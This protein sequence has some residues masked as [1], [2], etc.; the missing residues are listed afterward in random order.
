MCYD[1][2]QQVSVLRKAVL[3]ELCTNETI[4]E[5]FHQFYLALQ[6]SKT[7]KDY[8]LLNLMTMTLMMNKSLDTFEMIIT[9]SSK[10]SY[11]N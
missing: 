1:S 4:P 2:K 9:L 8:H 6:T 10:I 5:E 7:E 3:D 11:R